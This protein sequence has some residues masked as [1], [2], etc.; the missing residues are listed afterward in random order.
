MEEPKQKCWREEVDENLKRLH[1]FGADDALEK[2]DF[3]S[4][5]ILGLR[6]VGFLDSHCHSDIDEAFIYPIRREAM[7]KIV[8]AR[9]SLIP[10]SDRYL[11]LSSFFKLN[12][13]IL[14]L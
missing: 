9:R 10:D 7:A 1:S 14:S 12:S 2:Q 4:A 6:L 11:F 5:Q 8:S 3:V 13:S